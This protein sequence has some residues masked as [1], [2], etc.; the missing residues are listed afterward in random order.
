MPVPVII[1]VAVLGA[2]WLG[3]SIHRLRREWDREWRRIRGIE[4]E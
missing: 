2:V 4:E 3:V 1:A